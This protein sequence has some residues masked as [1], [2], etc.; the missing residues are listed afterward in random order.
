MYP[1]TKTRNN[2]KFRRTKKTTRAVAESRAEKPGKTALE[3]TT[4]Y[5]HTAKPGPFVWK[6]NWCR[7]RAAAWLMVA[8]INRDVGRRYGWC[9]HARLYPDGV[10]MNNAKMRLCSFFVDSRA[11]LCFCR[12]CGSW[13][14]VRS[15]L[16]CPF[17]LWVVI[18]IWIRPKWICGSWVY[19][20]E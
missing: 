3:N 20:F 2:N 12:L 9:T 17:E 7:T 10:R 8:L 19:R 5:K 18:Q 6:N 13:R 15:G 1:K 11:F 4:G 14:R 16:V